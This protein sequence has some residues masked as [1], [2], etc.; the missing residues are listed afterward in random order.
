M[1][2]KRIVS[3]QKLCDPCG[4]P[5]ETHTVDAGGREVELDLCVRHA[6]SLREI[7]DLIATFG[8]LVGSEAPIV[9]EQAPARKRRTPSTPAR[10]TVAGKRVTCGECGSEVAYSGRYRHVKEHG[11]RAADVTWTPAGP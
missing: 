8:R 1:V 7:L 4:R 10:A 5:A 3:T 6:R 2:T 11:K 9:E